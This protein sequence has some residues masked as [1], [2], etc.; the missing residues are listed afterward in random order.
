[1][2]GKVFENQIF[3]YN[4][5]TNRRTF[6]ED[7]HYHTNYELY[8]LIDGTTKYIIGDEA[9]RVQ[10]GDFVFVPKSIP[11]KTDS[12]ECL[13]NERLLVSF[14]DSVFEGDMSVVLE[15]LSREKLIAVDKNNLTDITELL[16]KL[17]M[18]YYNNYP[19]KEIVFKNY[20]RELL[21]LIC[22]Y[23]SKE[24]Q[25]ISDSDRIIYEIADY[26]SAN[27]S[28][29]LSLE[30]LSKRFTISKGQLSR[31]FRSVMGT[32]LNEYIRYIR[33]LNGEKLLRDTGFSV[34]EVAERCGFN[35][36][37]YFSAVFKGAMG[38][39]PLQYRKISKI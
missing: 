19:Y 7:F 10:S 4:K 27:F 35:D 2:Y 16:Q 13:H 22:R 12:E 28:E 26:I 25:I 31:K 6:M 39:T 20:V 33:I 8:Y 9:F 5:V 15:E 1:M 14:D 38:I 3:S 23:R 34:T 32:G 29:E 36:S 37:N 11:H 30:M 24:K 21:T 17:Q 18:E